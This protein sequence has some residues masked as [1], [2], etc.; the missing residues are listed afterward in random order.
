MTKQEVRP[1]RKASRLR[2]DRLPMVMLF[3]ETC[4]DTTEHRH[5]H[6]TAHGLEQ[7]HMAGT[8]RFQCT[9]CNHSVYKAEGARRGFADKFILD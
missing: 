1:I 2:R 9:E 4:N 7:T 3:C 8:E 6:D 5:M